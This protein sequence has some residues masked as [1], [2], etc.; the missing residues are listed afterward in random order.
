M[1][2]HNIL[3]SS[4]IVSALTA[5]SRVTGLAREMLMAHYFGTSLAKSA[6]DVAFRI[7]N[8][9]RNL[10]GE[11]ALS[12]AF[13]PVF[14]ESIEREGA[15]KAHDMAGRMMTLLGVALA[16]IVLVGVL[17][18]TA[19]IAFVPLGEKAAAVLPL[20]RIMLPYAFFICLV[21]L[22][23]AVL[24][25]FHRFALAAFTPVLMNVT[26]ILTLVFICP[27]YGKGVWDRIYVAAWGVIGAGALQFMCQIPALAKVGFRPGVSFAWRHDE[28]I[29]K[30]LQRMAPVALG[31]GVFQVN[32]AVDS[33][34]ALII[35][36][37]AAA[38]LNYAQEIVYLPLALFGTAMGT[39]LLPTFSRHVARNETG[40]ILQTINL[41][42]RNL[43]LLMV[44]ASV[45]LLV[46]A[47]PIVQLIF[48]SKSGHFTA[49]STFYT[50]RAVAFFAPGLVF[51]GV[52]KI[53]VPV[54]YAFKDTRTPVRIGVAVVALNFALNVISVITLPLYFKHAGMALSTVIASIVN[55]VVLGY[56]L[57]KR[58]GSPGWGRIARAAGGAVAASAIMGVAVF[59]AYAWLEAAVA[60]TGW[61]MKTGQ[62]AA[63]AGS[64]VVGLLVY[65]L[66]ASVLC[67]Q[68]VHDL[69]GRKRRSVEPQDAGNGV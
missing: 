46:L 44:P 14:S 5:L 31:L 59:Y 49:D 41:A 15:G 18:V 2:E 43:I 22:G 52:Y 34:L 57:H 69:I 36:G 45:G 24:N 20:L 68:E 4:H 58:L 13:V 61:G 39:V 11:G 8:L 12:A 1:T 50:A 21:A 27:W 54:F 64:V 23:M 40:E 38:A 35:A 66:L 60:R 65:G 37:W 55:C 47:T 19:V 42:M 17:L 28:R 6:F 56:I 10:L 62:I 63:V 26:M 53:L 9:F 16:V 3:R 7:P 48:A 30:V 32:V 25:S 51:F 33:V 67:R 29:R